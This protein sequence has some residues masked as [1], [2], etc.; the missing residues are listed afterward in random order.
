MSSDLAFIFAAVAVF[1][2]IAGVGFALIPSGNK[3]QTERVTQAVGA[4][5]HRGRRHT[6]ALDMAAQKKKQIQD[7]IKDIEER[8]KLARKRKV[9]LKA[10]IEQAGMTF[11]P[12]Q[13]WIGSGV[14]GAIVF[15]TI[16][17]LGQ[18]ILIA[19][20]LSVSAGL[21]LPRWILGMITAKRQKKFT[22][23]FADALEII[24]RGIKSGLPLHECLKIIAADTPEPIKSEF[25][26]LIEGIAV[27]VP[28]DEGLRRMTERM[29]LPELNFF[30][31]VLTIQ[32]KTGG[33]LAEALGNL[34]IVL[35]SRKMMREKIGALSSEAKASAGI[36]GALPPLLLVIISLVS[37]GYTDVLFT[38][39]KGQFLLIGGVVWMGIGILVMRGMINFKM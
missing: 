36:I 9:S 13:F 32:Q 29:P 5:L 33:N 28:V 16:L 39:P 38:Q 6:A 25:Q 1:I 17:V 4:P 34:A 31:I 30:S 11:T 2:A 18:H 24:V 10:R 3:R 22:E 26:E 21:G 14:I 23:N 15:V 12:Q 35:R 27:G 7:S 8:Q 37:P 19:A 20:G